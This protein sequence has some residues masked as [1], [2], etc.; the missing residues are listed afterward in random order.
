MRDIRGLFINIAGLIKSQ[1]TALGDSFI[2]IT[3][4]RRGIIDNLKLTG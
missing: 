3:Q 4:T 2:W 1:L